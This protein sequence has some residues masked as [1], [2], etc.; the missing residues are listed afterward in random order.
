LRSGEWRGGVSF[1]RLLDMAV[2]I[3]LVLGLLALF[4]ITI[5]TAVFGV[6][7]FFFTLGLY[8]VIF[9]AFAKS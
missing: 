5:M 6:G 1:D 7:G 2:F 8:A 9:F 3:R 4:F